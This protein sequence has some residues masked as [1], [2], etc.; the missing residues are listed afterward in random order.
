[1]VPPCQA[2]SCHSFQFF[3]PYKTDISLRRCL[4]PSRVISIT[5]LIHSFKHFSFVL[6]LFHDLVIVIGCR[7]QLFFMFS[8]S[9]YWSC[10]GGWREVLLVFPPPAP[11]HPPCP[12][13]IAPDTSDLPP[14]QTLY[15]WRFNLPPFP[16]NQK[17][18]LPLLR[19]VSLGVFWMIY[20]VL[21]KDS[22]T[23]R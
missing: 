1:M 7:S 11:P 21:I 2:L 23:L 4:S 9:N 5:R 17:Y 22:Y 12:F 15:S 19:L 3:T 18:R 16:Q 6:L 14:T 13:I 10:K 8:S 20:E